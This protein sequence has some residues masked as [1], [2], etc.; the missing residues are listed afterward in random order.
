MWEVAH[1][2]V[3]AVREISPTGICDE[4]EERSKYNEVV[5]LFQRIKKN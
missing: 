5:D 2:S 1:D 4:I 3:V